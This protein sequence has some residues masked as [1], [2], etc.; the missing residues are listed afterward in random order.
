MCSTIVAEPS[1]LGGVRREPFASLDL[2]EWARMTE[3]ELDELSD[4]DDFS[5]DELC[6]E[7]VHDDKVTDQQR[8]DDKECDARVVDNV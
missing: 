7:E 1:P 4:S 8:A 2:P 6:D 5:D 3:K